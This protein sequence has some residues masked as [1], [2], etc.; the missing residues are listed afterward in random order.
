M[1]QGTDGNQAGLAAIVSVGIC[2]VWALYSIYYF[3]ALFG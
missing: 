2:A 1:A 3:M